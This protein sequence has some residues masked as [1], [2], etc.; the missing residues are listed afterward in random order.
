M[1]T[2]LNKTG[3]HIWYQY[4][5]PYTWQRHGEHYCTRLIRWVYL[6]AT[7]LCTYSDVHHA[8]RIAPT[9]LG[10]AY[11]GLQWITQNYSNGGL[12]SYRSGFDMGDSWGL[13]GEQVSER[14]NGRGIR[15]RMIMLLGFR[16]ME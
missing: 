3:R 9:L 7:G 14:L 12:N 1:G 5:S 8:F 2:A 11:G 15:S 13:V 4:G 6:S 16:S 10:G